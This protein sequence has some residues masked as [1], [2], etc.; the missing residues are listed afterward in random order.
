MRSK[1]QLAVFLSKL[2][3]FTSPKAYL[4]QYSTD[5]E[6]AADVLWNAYLLGDVSNK[7]VADLGAGTG[8]LGRGCLE[9]QAKKVFFLEKDESLIKVL[10]Q[11]AKE[12]VILNRDITEFDKKVD[13]VIMNPPFGVQKRKADKVFLEKAIL[14]A[15]VVYMLGKVEGDGFVDAIAK[16]HGAKITHRW[17]YSMPL[18]ATQKFHT[19]K[20]HLVEVM[21]WRVVIMQ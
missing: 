19:K 6:V 3:V 5:S 7:V 17:K 2:P 1:S 16:E 10:E 21:C 13:T 9:L 12:G 4:E 11:T 18:K 14:N 20:K 8:I 15:K